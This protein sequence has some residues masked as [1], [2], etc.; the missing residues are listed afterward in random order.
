MYYVYSRSDTDS[1][2]ILSQT[3]IG[4]ARD[5]LQRWHTASGWQIKF[6]ILVETSTYE[7]AA[8]YL[9][10]KSVTAQVDPFT[11]IRKGNKPELEIPF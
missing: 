11:L 4:A 8:E 2:G 6:R 10:Q 3:N 9:P 5:E 7:H 1:V